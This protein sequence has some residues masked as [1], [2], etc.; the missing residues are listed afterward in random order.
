MNL[1]TNITA[2]SVPRFGAFL[3]FRHDFKKLL[4]FAMQKSRCAFKR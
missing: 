4:E 1:H 2:P 3:V